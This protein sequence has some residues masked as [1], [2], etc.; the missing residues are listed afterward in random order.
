[1]EMQSASTIAPSLGLPVSR[2][3]EIIRIMDFKRVIITGASS[4]FGAAYARRL[5]AASTSIVLIARREEKLRELQQELSAA[6]PQLQV[7]ICPCDLSQAAEREILIADLLK[8]TGTGAILLIN[9]AGLGDYGDFSESEYERTRQ[10]MEVNMIALTQLSHALIPQLKVQGGA[11]IN[12]ASLAADSF[13][14]D[15]AVYAAT[16]A[17]VAYLSEALHI[18]LRQDGIP[19][20]AVCPGPVHTGFGIVARREGFTGNMLP[21]KLCFDTSVKTVIDGSLKALSAG[22]SRYYPSLKVRAMAL[23]VRNTP[24]CLLRCIL[25]FRPRRVKP[26]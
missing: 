15:F 21:L 10:M 13:I 7:Q 2:L 17:Y 3:R 4:G 14:P 6:H 16:K 12:I 1:M 24:L 22:K 5:A 23:L 18:E 11:I 19:V 9:N 25:S 26:Q 8:H 20:L